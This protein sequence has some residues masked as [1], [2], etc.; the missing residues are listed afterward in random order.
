M[1]TGEDGSKNDIWFV[2][3]RRYFLML[4]VSNMLWNLCRI[5]PSCRVQDSGSSVGR[6]DRNQF[7]R[8][9]RLIG[10]PST[11]QLKN[12]PCFPARGST[13][14]VVDGKADLHHHLSG[15]KSGSVWCS[16][17]CTLV[18]TQNLCCSLETSVL[19]ISSRF[20]L[21]YQV[22]WVQQQQY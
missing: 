11:S 2:S 12:H 3:Q 16:Y 5:L 21:L 8:V 7:L 10:L 22:Q 6:L 15:D 19:H 13:P 4:G 18:R 17:C 14:S 20:L 1:G 9:Q